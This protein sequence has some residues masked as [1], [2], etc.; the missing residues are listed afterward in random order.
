MQMATTQK[1]RATGWILL[2][3]F[4]GPWVTA[5]VV[6]A[7][8]EQFSFNTVE[9]GE[10]LSPPI[11]AQ[12]LPFFDAA[13]LGKWQ[14]LY[15]TP[16]ECDASCQT[17]MPKLKQLHRALAKDQHRVEYRSIQTSGTPLLNATDIAIVDP[18]GWIMMRYSA[19]IDPQLI[20]KDLRR[21]LKYSH[22]G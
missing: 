1:S 8:R 5:H 19:D 18:N 22:V 2:L 12:S 17:L 4:I 3:V 20:L 10:L 11:Q 14:I 15:F 7:L 9:K 13:W 16:A 6:Y 21:L